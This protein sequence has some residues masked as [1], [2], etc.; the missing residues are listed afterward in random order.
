MVDRT[1]RTLE[2]PVPESAPRT[3]CMDYWIGMEGREKASGR[4][5]ERVDYGTRRVTLV[6]VR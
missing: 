4:I 1:G 5:L 3:S 2:P 6:M